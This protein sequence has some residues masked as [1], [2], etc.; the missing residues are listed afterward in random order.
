MSK[1]KQKNYLLRVCLD[2]IANVF[3]EVYTKKETPKSYY[4]DLFLRLFILKND[5]VEKEA[6]KSMI[7]RATSH[8]YRVPFDDGDFVEVVFGDYRCL[9]ENVYAR[10]T[11]CIETPDYG[12]FFALNN[13]KVE[14]LK[15]DS[16]LSQTN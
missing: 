16:N 12:A 1:K 13:L 8:G 7:V 4:T 2:T 5:V 11:I 10:I 3:L 9:L 15:E 6:S 14:K